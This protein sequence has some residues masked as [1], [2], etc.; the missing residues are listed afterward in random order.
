MKF[1]SIFHKSLGTL[2]T[3]SAS[4]VQGAD[5]SEVNTIEMVSKGFG[6]GLVAVMSNS[7]E[8]MDCSLPGSSVHG[9]LQARMLEWVFIYF[10]RGSS[11]PRNWIRVSCIAGGFFTVWAMR[12]APSKGLKG[13]KIRE[14]WQV[15]A[16]HMGSCRPPDKEIKIP[17][18]LEIR[19]LILVQN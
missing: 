12:K 17:S 5:E 1:R 8:P 6:G 11:Q 14:D 18:K 3:Y 19:F 10:S 9:I 4:T 7:C 15:R 13:C 2:T 16:N